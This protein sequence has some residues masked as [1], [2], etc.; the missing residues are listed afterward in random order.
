MLPFGL[1]FLCLN[2]RQVAKRIA[3]RYALQEIVGQNRRVQE[4]NSYSDSTGTG[5]GARFS[6]V[7]CVSHWS[8][9]AVSVCSV[10]V[11]VQAYFQLFALVVR[12]FLL[13]NSS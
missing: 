5:F 11:S 4:C 9:W 12:I 7:I 8:L 3:L 1:Q 2:S 13:A 6:F 10:S